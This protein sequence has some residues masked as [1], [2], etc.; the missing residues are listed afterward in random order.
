MSP[1]PGW[2]AMFDVARESDLRRLTEVYVH[3]LIDTCT[4]EE[5]RSA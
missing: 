2:P 4:R 3:T 5:L 1:E